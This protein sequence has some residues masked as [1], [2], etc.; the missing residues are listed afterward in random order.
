MYKMLV[1]KIFIMAGD[2]KMD[3]ADLIKPILE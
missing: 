3:F 2:I 1:F